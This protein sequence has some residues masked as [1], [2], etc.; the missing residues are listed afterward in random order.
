[1]TAATPTRSAPMRIRPGKFGINSVPFFVIDW[2]Y[3][4]SGARPAELLTEALREA[5]AAGPSS[6]ERSA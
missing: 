3:G 4:F 2:K 6:G 1:M 5:W